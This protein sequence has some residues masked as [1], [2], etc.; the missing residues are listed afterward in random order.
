MH[1][2]TFNVSLGD[3]INNRRHFIVTL[4]PDN[5]D[6][7]LAYCP[8]LECVS[9]RYNDVTLRLYSSQSGGLPDRFVAKPDGEYHANLGV[10]MNKSAQDRDSDA[11]E[12][13]LVEGINNSSK[14]PMYL[15]NDLIVGYVSMRVT[16]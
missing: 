5:I 15:V 2:W 3:L 9:G 14:I 7:L 8:Q 12:R 1:E 16:I 4:R 13:D 6:F 10:F 11:I